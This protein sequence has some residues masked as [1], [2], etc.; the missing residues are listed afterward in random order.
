MGTWVI[1][2]NS[3]IGCQCLP[4]FPVK[5]AKCKNL[6]TKIGLIMRGS[7][8]QDKL[9]ELEKE[10]Q[11]AKGDLQTADKMLYEIRKI[12]KIDPE[13]FNE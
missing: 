9:T 3:C 7:D 6:K 8:F 11:A 13:Q 2:G 10:Y 4:E 5:C 12:V 1:D